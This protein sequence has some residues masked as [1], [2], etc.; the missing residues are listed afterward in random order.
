MKTTAYSRQLVSYYLT[1]IAAKVSILHTI[2]WCRVG[3]AP[4]ILCAAQSSAFENYPRD[5]L[6]DENHL[7]GI[8][9]VHINI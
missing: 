4:K 7:Y 9:L 8:V 2:K 6:C 1:N 3:I 5:I